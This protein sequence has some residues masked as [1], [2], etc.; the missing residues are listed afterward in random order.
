MEGNSMNFKIISPPNDLKVTNLNTWNPETMVDYEEHPAYTELVK[1]ANLVMRLRAI[2]RFLPSLGIIKIKRAIRYEMIPLHIREASGVIGFFLKAKLALL[3]LASFISIRKVDIEEEL[4]TDLEQT[5]YHQG[6]AVISPPLHFYKRLRKLSQKNFDFLETTRAAK[7]NKIRKFGE[8]RSYARRDKDEDLFKAIEELFTVSGV[9]KTA[10]KYLGR[11]VRLIDVN[12]QI[13]DPTDDFWMR[14]F[15]DLRLPKPSC[16]Y[17]H[18]DASGGDIK[19]IIY[20]SDVGSKNGPFGYVIGSHRMKLPA[21]VDHVAEANDSNGMSG[22]SFENRSYFSALPARWRYKGTFGN[23]VLNDTPLA[24]TIE[25]GHWSI[26]G[27]KG[28]IVMFD[29]KGVHR[30]GMVI[31]GKRRVITCILG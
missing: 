12:P 26:T 8:S 24:K 21:A 29:T 20:M 18:R 17:F 3:H 16:A 27:D 6:C 23:D 2:C 15:P 25:S 14:V 7:K 28:S 11:Q 30:G 5:F 19:V 31:S 9:F 13:N 4:K 22:T 10:N 1:S